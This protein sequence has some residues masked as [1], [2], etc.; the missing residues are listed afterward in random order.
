[1]AHPVFA[2]A[3]AVIATD[4]ALVH[5]DASGAPALIPVPLCVK[6]SVG[7]VRTLKMNDV[8]FLMPAHKRP[9]AQMAGADDAAEVDVAAVFA[10]AVYGAGV[11]V[12][13]DAAPEDQRV[14]GAARLP[15]AVAPNARHLRRGCEKAGFHIALSSHLALS[16]TP[17]GEISHPGRGIFDGRED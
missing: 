3:I 15:A 8:F 6:P 13:G 5:V 17:K 9:V 11:D 7:W 14:A 16:P 12:G 2:V 1:M 4:K 10:D